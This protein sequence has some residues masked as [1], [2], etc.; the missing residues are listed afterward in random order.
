M[1]KLNALEAKIILRCQ[2]KRFVKEI[3]QILVSFDKRRYNYQY[4]AQKCQE[5]YYSGFLLKSVMK[6]KGNRVYYCATDEAIQQA[7]EVL[8][9]VGEERQREKTIII[10]TTK[11]RRLTEFV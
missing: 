7:V 9:T 6:I 11:N 8:N 3:W 2:K 1:E 5:L 4:I 10:I